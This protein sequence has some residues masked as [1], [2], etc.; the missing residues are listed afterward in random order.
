[1]IAVIDMTQDVSVC[2]YTGFSP[3]RWFLTIGY[4][5]PYCF[6]VIF[7]GGQNCDEGGQSRNWEIPPLLKILIYL[8]MVFF[9]FVESVSLG[10]LGDSFYEYLLKSWLQSGKTDNSARKL[11]DEAMKVSQC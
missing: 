5:F 11:Y 7:V 3:G 1:M 4:C 2:V 9:K 6:L 10:A 8:T